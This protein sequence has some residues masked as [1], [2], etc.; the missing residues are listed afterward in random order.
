M[1]DARLVGTA[2]RGDDAVIEHAARRGDHR[3]S[4]ES[5]PG[6]SRSLISP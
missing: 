1:I 2:I 6:R 3:C 5:E 4:A